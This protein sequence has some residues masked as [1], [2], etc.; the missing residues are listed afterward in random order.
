MVNFMKNVPD[1]LLSSTFH[2][3]R[4]IFSI[5]FCS[6]FDF[7]FMYSSFLYY[8]L[9]YCSTFEEAS[10]WFKSLLTTDYKH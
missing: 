4:V 1:P 7:F 10:G 8:F 3:G 5:V 2:L 6:M 9:Y